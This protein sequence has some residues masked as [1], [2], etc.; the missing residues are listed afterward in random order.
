[1]REFE[2]N[3]VK[4][5]CGRLN[6]FEQLHVFRKLAPVIGAAGSLVD[7]LKPK[8]GGALDVRIDDMMPLITAIAEMP[9]TDLD[10]VIRKCLS[11]VE[12]A[13]DTAVG[14]GWAKVWSASAE[15]VMFDDID[16]AMSMV[17]IAIAVIQDNL[18]NFSFALPSR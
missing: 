15:R 10:T 16:N 13:Q 14:T 1:M 7:V 4:Y 3:G 5:R 8:A 6:A 9:E 2:V 11:V 12:R 18:G 17:Q